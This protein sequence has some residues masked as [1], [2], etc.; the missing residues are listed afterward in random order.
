MKAS[1]I[2]TFAD[3]IREIYERQDPRRTSWRTIGRCAMVLSAEVI[4]NGKAKLYERIIAEQ[5]DLYYI[6]DEELPDSEQFSIFMEVCKSY[7]AHKFPKAAPPEEAAPPEKTE[8]TIPPQES[9]KSLTDILKTFNVPRWTGPPISSVSQL[10]DAVARSSDNTRQLLEAINR[11]NH[12]RQ[13]EMMSF[14]EF[15]RL[16]PGSTVEVLPNNAE[17]IRSNDQ[18]ITLNELRRIRNEWAPHSNPIGEEIVL[19]LQVPLP[20][21]VQITAEEFNQNTRDYIDAMA[22]AYGTPQA[23]IVEQQEAEPELPF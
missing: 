14:E 2:T 16:N 5:A 9:I 18:G 7:F 20:A 6:S 1:E 4:D 11:D 19:P 3:F 8:E 15:Q 22:L 10:G 12:G 23:P 17:V 21:S 13:M